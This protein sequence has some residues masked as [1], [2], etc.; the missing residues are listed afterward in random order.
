[1][2]TEHEHCWHPRSHTYEYTARWMECCAV[3]CEEIRSQTSAERV[4]AIADEYGQD[5][6]LRKLQDDQK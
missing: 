6:L 3:S 2:S 4:D 1:M 5:A